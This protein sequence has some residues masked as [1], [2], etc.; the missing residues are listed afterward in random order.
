MCRWAPDLGS[1]NSNNLVVTPALRTLPVTFC[2]LQEF[3]RLV[4]HRSARS[5]KLKS[6]YSETIVGNPECEKANFLPYPLIT[7]Y[8]NAVPP[9]KINIFIGVK[10]GPRAVSTGQGN[11]DL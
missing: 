3:R 1:F 10:P 5:V 11:G 7:P 4:V 8:P 9:M 6:V 2:E